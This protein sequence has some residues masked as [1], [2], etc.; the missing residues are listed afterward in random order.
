MG[1][2]LTSRIA[3]FARARWIELCFCVFVLANTAGILILQE[4]STVPFHF[5]WIALSVVYGWLV[6]SIRATLAVLASVIVL[7]GATLGVNVVLG[8]DRPDDLTEVP[9]MAIVFLVMV[10]YVRR[11]VAAKEETRRVSEHNLALLQQQRQLIQDTS[12]VIRTPLT[13]ALGHA[14][15]VRRTTADPIA[16]HD[17]QVIVEELNRLKMVSD[18]LLALAATE[19]PDFVHPVPT[20][21]RDLVTH[22]W[23]RW[24]PTCPAVELGEV[25]EASV[26][27]DPA[28]FLEALDELVANA[29]QHTPPG[30]PIRLS[31]HGQDGWLVVAVADDGPGIPRHEQGRVLQRF[32]RLETRDQGKGL[33]LGLA[34]VEAIAE[35]HGGSVAVR[36]E[37]GR[38]A[39]F[40]LWF[41]VRG[42]GPDAGDLPEHEAAAETVP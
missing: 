12:H 38:G 32:A 10:W 24:S 29:V 28:R 23:S 9:L 39:T 37:P 27:V 16:A 14:E 15:L 42:V 7:T 11:H 3:R 18:R 5:I 17:S 4:W 8:G 20:P 30:T 34:M 31:A 26:P 33:G 13:I 2:T 1:W 40:E 21:I 36:S 41:P 19:Q 22:A 6:W 25:I 35:A